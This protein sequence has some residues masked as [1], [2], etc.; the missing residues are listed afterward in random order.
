MEEH[1]I[2]KEETMAENTKVLWDEA[3]LAENDVMS[4]ASEMSK[5]AEAHSFQ[6]LYRL[7]EP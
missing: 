1:A 3:R 7:A 2:Q 4:E 5:K 6:S